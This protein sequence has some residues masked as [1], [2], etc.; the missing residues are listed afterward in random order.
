MARLPFNPDLVSPPDPPEVKGPP[1]G[2]RDDNT[3][4][5]TQV[6]SLIKD[7]LAT[8]LP[9][10]LRVVGEVS[11][12]SDR[13]H[14]FFSLKDSGAALRCVCFASAARRVKFKMADGMQVVATGR[15]DLYDAQGNVQLY[16]DKLEPIGVGELEL[17]FR[18]LCD[19]LRQDGYFD[20]DRK[21]P[22]PVM[23]RRIAVVTSRAA[24]ALQDVINTA[25]RRWPG[26]QLLLYDVRVQGES[27]APEIAAAINALSKHG[28]KLGIDA[29]ILTRGGGSIEDLWAFN[30]RAVADAVFRCTLPIVAAI[31]HETDTTIAELVA[32]AR[33]ATPTQAAMTLIP[34]K[35]AIDDQ[36]DQLSRRLRLL[37]ARQVR[38]ANQRVES[39]ARHTMF[40]RP[41]RMVEPMRQRLDQ[42]ARELT[43]LVP[44]RTEEAKTRLA[45]LGKHLES[46]GPVNVLARGYSFTL[47]QDGHVLRSTGD[48]AAGDQLTTVLSDGRV[49]SRVE[50]GEAAPPKPRRKRSKKSDGEDEPRLF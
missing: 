5:V 27:A 10:K 16:V 34:D 6:A 33:C 23:P 11:N 24:A 8:G 49:V 39:A 42:L 20:I 38:E 13:Q 28:P 41:Q 22:L 14:W 35:A 48:V 25:T 7:A 19:E 29:V 3:L 40:R 9:A 45:S 1:R 21:Q 46:V 15:I 47:G 36:L 30:E 4:T 2:R 31:G 50:G 18:A 17:R 32:D 37:V 12:L 43:S 44:R 26:C